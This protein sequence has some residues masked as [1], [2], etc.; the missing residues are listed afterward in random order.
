MATVLNQPGTHPSSYIYIYTKY[1]H[2]FF[3]HIYLCVEV[4]RAIA[5]WKEVDRLGLASAETYTMNL[6]YVY[7]YVNPVSTQLYNHLS[8]LRCMSCL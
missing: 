4:D 5:F 1:Y 3:F 8:I 2:L 6:S 7:M